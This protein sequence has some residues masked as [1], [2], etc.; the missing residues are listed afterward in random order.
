[1]TW[2]LWLDYLRLDVFGWLEGRPGGFGGV[3]RVWRHVLWT[4]DF[5]WVTSFAQL[6]WLSCT[7]LCLELLVW[8]SL[9]MNKKMMNRCR[10]IIDVFG[11]CMSEWKRR[12]H[13][14]YQR[15]GIRD[16]LKEKIKFVEFQGLT[17]LL[18][19]FMH[20]LSDYSWEYI[21]NKLVLV[22][23][24]I[25][26]ITWTIRKSPIN[27]RVRWKLKDCADCITEM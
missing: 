10:S 1:M 14:N 18:F 5:S 12:Q 4:W 15:L 17:K 21:I 26:G 8:I 16:R 23:L 6:C 11:Q 22:Y 3:W 9:R 25:I 19:S 20:S 7:N 24:V 2:R 27:P 13:H